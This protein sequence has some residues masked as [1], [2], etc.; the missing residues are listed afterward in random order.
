MEIS[1]SHFDSLMFVCSKF[2]Y[3]II[4]LFYVDDLLLTGRITNFWHPQ[5]AI[6]IFAL[7][8]LDNLGCFLG[9]EAICQDDL[10]SLSYSRYNHD[11][12]THTHMI[13]AKPISS[14]VIFGKQV[15]LYDGDPL[16]DPSLYR[17]T[18]GVLQYLTLTLLEITFAINQA[19]QF[20]HN[21]ITVYQQGVKCI[22]KVFKRYNSTGHYFRTCFYLTT[23]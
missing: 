13:G 17:S 19:C 9:I 15:F 20:M 12:L 18:V 7:K 14:R 21:P 8:D 3:V 23:C 10:L 1:A 16:F 2:H 5:S 4:L 22:L 11:L 6:L